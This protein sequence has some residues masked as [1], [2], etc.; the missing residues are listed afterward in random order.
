[1]LPGFSAGQLRAGDIQ[2]IIDRWRIH[3]GDHLQGRIHPGRSVTG[4]IH[5]GGSVTGANTSRGMSYRGGYIQEISYGADTS[6]GI[7]YRGGY[8]QGIS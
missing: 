2:G 1:M 4:R 6:R 8:I 3:T 5:P 7:S